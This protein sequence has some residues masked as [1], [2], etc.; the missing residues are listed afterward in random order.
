MKNCFRFLSSQGLTQAYFMK[1]SI[2]HNKHLTPQFLEDN[3]LISAKSA[4]QILS[5]NFAYILVLWNF[6]ITGLCNS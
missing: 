2:M 5:L 4:A 3:D 1:T 6:L